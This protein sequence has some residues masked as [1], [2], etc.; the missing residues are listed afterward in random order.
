MEATAAGARRMADGGRA[1][2]PGLPDAHAA[3]R[4]SLGFQPK[5]RSIRRFVKSR[6]RA[7]APGR[8]TFEGVETTYAASVRGRHLSTHGLEAAELR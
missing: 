6:R 4:P 7:R 5:L 8:F 2:S 1:G 3:R